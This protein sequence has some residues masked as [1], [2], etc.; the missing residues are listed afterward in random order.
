MARHA[1]R[2]GLA[3]T[4]CVMG[5][6]AGCNL[7]LGIEEQPAR[8]RLVDA[9]DDAPA[10]SPASR[11]AFEAC[12]RD[13][14]CVPPNACYTPHCDT[15]L[16]ACTY[17]LC[18]AAD[19]TCAA[20]VC[21]PA[22]FACS[23]PIPYGFRSTS[24]DVNA[25]TSGCGPNPAAC[26]AAVFPFVFIGGRDEVTAL[27]GDDLA[28][29]AP[30]KVTVTGLTTKPEQVI[31][32][33]RRLWVLGAVQGTAPPYRL[34]VATIDVPSDPT[35]RELVAQTVLAT[36][37]FPSARAFPAP[38]GGLF[39]AL[40]DPTLGFPAAALQAPLTEGA[41][42]GLGSATDAGAFD[43]SARD[44]AGSITMYRAAGVPAG[45]TLV[46]S[47][48]ARLVVHRTPSTFNLV[49]GA[50]TPSA[51]TLPDQGL[52]AP[53][54]PI[55]P[56]TFAQGPNGAVMMAAS[57]AAD[58]PGDCNCTTH[59]RLQYVF[60]NG[61]A[62][63]TDVNQLLDPETYTNPQIAGMACHAC[64]PDYYRPRVLATWLGPR[65]A[66]SASPFGGPAA[67][68][69][70]TEVR[71]LRR[72]PLD[73]DAKRRAQTKA[74]E[75]PKG[76][77]ATDRVALTSSNGIGYLILADG[78]GNDVSLSIYDARCDPK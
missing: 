7:V 9:S 63:T 42:F 14:D 50:G 3:A 46:A 77:F 52:N 76:D 40:N 18:E 35:V 37:P 4:F 27:L 72:D 56:P 51:R 70:L 32:S 29:A 39:V 21:D 2:R 68:R 28:G 62:T 69:A 78:Q 45:S 22:T 49:D 13:V 38:N 74:T 55:G 65:G 41:S 17:A 33:G 25:A 57:V 75:T 36:Y 12:A 61:D 48:G 31:A 1:T 60:P 58:P 64:A 23:D 71:Y 59:A 15:V 67:S 44:E 16:G 30:V 10:V 34:P 53:L 73:I 11:P 26:V 6:I 66:L 8:P 19:R 24:Y 20:G 47:S 43:A 54:V 5:A